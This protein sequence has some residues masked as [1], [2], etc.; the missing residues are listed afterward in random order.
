MLGYTRIVFLRHI[1]DRKDTLCQIGRK[2]PRGLEPSCLKRVLVFD[3]VE[4]G[5]HVSREQSHESHF[6]D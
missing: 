2:Q 1:A 4:Y 6:Q 3:S 5:D